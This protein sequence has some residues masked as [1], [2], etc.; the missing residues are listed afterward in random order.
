MA[1]GK[2]G[3]C[4]LKVLKDR[5]LGENPVPSPFSWTM[6]WDSVCVLCEPGPQNQHLGSDRG[7]R[8]QGLRVE[9]R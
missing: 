2:K 6:S 3:V 9:A 8:R 5:A 1:L 7:R 4:F